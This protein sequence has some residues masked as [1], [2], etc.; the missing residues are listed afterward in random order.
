M[1]GHP[2]ETDL[3]KNPA[4]YVPLTPL[5]FLARA[6]AVFPSRTS[7]IHGDQRF[8]WAETRDRCHRLASALSKHGITKGDTVTVMAPNVP[9]SFE[10]TFGV[11]MTGAVLNALNIRL[12]ASTIAFILNH[13]EAKALI[14]DRKFSKEDL[15]RIIDEKRQ[16]IRKSGILDFIGL[17]TTLANVGGLGKLKEWL[18]ERG[19]AF[20]NKAREYGLPEPKGL[21]ML[22]VQGCGKSLAAKAIASEAE[23]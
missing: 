10:A 17:S 15:P 3:D 2:F 13:G 21:L 8:T 1:S 9:P 6:A 20:S 19:G 5:S 18:R 16:L 7:V 14:T 11:P 4:N 12:D 22:G 23:P